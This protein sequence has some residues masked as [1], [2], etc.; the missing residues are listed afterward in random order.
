MSVIQLM[1]S[2][3]GC[4]IIFLPKLLSAGHNNSFSGG[5]RR[6]LLIDVCLQRVI[7]RYL[8]V[9]SVVCVTKQLTQCCPWLPKGEDFS[10][11]WSMRSPL[12]SH[13]LLVAIISMDILQSRC[14]YPSTGCFSTVSPSWLA[15]PKSSWSERI[16]IRSSLK[17]DTKALHQRANRSDD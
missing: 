4:S 14:L 16:L 12:R 11:D 7:S 8:P 15:N 1:G 2:C 3:S 6:S 13:C 10:H 9:P 5:T 17:W